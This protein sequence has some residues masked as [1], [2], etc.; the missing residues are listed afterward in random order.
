MFCSIFS[1][2]AKVD[3]NILI[4]GIYTNLNYTKG[5]TDCLQTQWQQFYLK[6]TSFSTFV[7]VPTVSGKNYIPKLVVFNFNI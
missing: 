3:Y 4:K 6:K 2:W 5:K 1:P 7:S